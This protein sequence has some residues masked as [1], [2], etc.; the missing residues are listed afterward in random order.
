MATSSKVVCAALRAV[1]WRGY[2]PGKMMADGILLFYKENSLLPKGLEMSVP[3]VQDWGMKNGVAVAR[4]VA[5]IDS[6]SV[7]F[8]GCPTVVDT[9]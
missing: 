4:L 7:F 2:V 9:V 3:A 6:E 5:Q 1:K 8:C